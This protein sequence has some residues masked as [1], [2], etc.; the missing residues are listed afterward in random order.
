MIASLF[1][2]TK[3]YNSSLMDEESY[4][5]SHKSVTQKSLEKLNNG[6]LEVTPSNNTILHL[7]SMLGNVKYANNIIKEH[8]SL[9]YIRNSEGETAAYVAAS[10]GHMDILEIM[11]HYFKIKKDDIESLVT[12]TMDNNTAL[13]VAIQNHHVGVI[14]LLIKQ[15]PQLANRI[16]NLKES[17]IYLVAERGS[18]HR[19]LKLILDNCEHRTF[20]GPN[21]RTALHAAAISGSSESIKYMLS[22]N[23]HLIYKPD[24][25]HRIP[26]QYAVLHNNA[27]AT[28]ALLKIDTSV[29]YKKVMEDG[30]E[31]SL[32]HI[33][34][35]QGHQALVNLLILKCRRCSE[36]IDGKG[37]NILHVAIDNKKTEVV[38]YIFKKESLSF[39]INQKD[40]DGNTPIHLYMASE[41]DM[42][43]TLMDSRVNMNILNNQ[44]NTP[45]DVASS[46]IKR[47]RLLKAV[48]MGIP[49]G[50]TA[51]PV[52]QDTA[53]D[54]E[55]NNTYKHVNE[56]LVV[57][58]LIATAS[59]AAAFTVP[60]GFDSDEG[61]D[62]AGMP[63]LLKKA[64]FKAFMTT[65]TV[66]FSCA[67]AAIFGYFNLIVLRRSNTKIVT[68]KIFRGVFKVAIHIRIFT[69][70]AIIAMSIAFATGIYVV[71]TPYPALAI[72]LCF[73]ALLIN[74]Y[75]FCFT[76]P[77]DN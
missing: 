41:L 37:R 46:S 47:N 77:K 51:A 55:L 3:V 42:I 25:Y 10:E 58:T 18:Y 12:R 9:L 35:S 48:E 68:P 29:G 65:N 34:S 72:S 66:A 28:E 76:I 60:G 2:E 33:A 63:I 44:G 16:N 74:Y 7:V 15:I 13:H 11:I 6:V 5:Y 4:P 45:L 21:G 24:D 1:T 73:I 8:P 62:H 23:R 59:F 31:S 75:S 54:E 67:C 64:A 20:E 40:K 49:I 50:R 43:E 19:I 26:L 56:L 27:Q 39:L 61:S 69:L 70:S 30:I 14:F 32:V 17:P 71:L 53:S 52:K 38:E 36:M 57:V 22:E